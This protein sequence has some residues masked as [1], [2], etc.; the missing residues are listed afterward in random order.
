ITGMHIEDRTEILQNLRAGQEA[1]VASLANIPEDL[2]TRV[3]GP[4]KWSIL[5][6]VEHVAV[7]EDYLFHQISNAKRSEVPMLNIAREAAILDRG[8]DRTRKVQSPEVAQPRGRFATV[9]DALGS[10]QATRRRTIQFV[11]DCLDD[12]RTMM[13]HHPLIGTVNNYEL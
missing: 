1:F 2:A 7:A 8:T 6:C 12:P 10:F 13:A 5:E 4:G 3:P 9:T 11:E